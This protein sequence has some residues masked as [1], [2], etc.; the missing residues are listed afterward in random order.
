MRRILALASVFALAACMITPMG[1]AAVQQ[2]SQEFNM[3]TRFGRMEVAGR[4]RQPDTYQARVRPAPPLWGNALHVTDAEIV[5][6]KM[7]G[8]E[9]ATSSSASAGTA[10]IEG[11]LLT[12]TV[13]KQKWHRFTGQL[14]PRRRR[15]RSTAPSARSARRSRSSRPTRRRCTRS[16]RRCASAAQ[17]TRTQAEAE[18]FA[19]FFAAG[20]FVARLLGA[21]G[22]GDGLEAALLLALCATALHLHRVATIEVYP[23]WAAPCRDLGTPVK[24][25][26]ADKCPTRQPALSATA[27]SRLRTSSR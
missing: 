15:A 12:T 25:E 17:P 20:F 9:D 8:D 27:S 1:A 7:N 21:L 24:P 2:T 19:D 10:S 4:G 18:A 3:H 5:G 14:A 11:D 22:G 23:W 26:S 16:F 13:V 6:M